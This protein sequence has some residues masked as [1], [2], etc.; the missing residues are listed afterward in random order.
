[1][2]SEGE[3]YIER[4]REAFRR[5]KMIFSLALAIIAGVGGYLVLH[6]GHPAE[7]TLKKAFR[8]VE[9]GDAAGVLALVDEE[10]PLGVL[11]D[12]DGGRLKRDF[13]GFI[14]KYRLEI[15]SPSFRV[16]S[17]KN[18]A[19]VEL[20]GGTVRVHSRSGSGIPL[21]ALGLGDSGLVFYMEKKEG[22]WLV[23]DV[24]YDLTQWI[25]GE[26]LPFSW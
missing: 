22:K 11:L 25:T 3:V 9:E 20:T 7:A 5:F 21:A 26:S 15:S 12:Q 1:M 19:E 17:E 16:R 8:M 10:G 2:T 6:R 14:E 4:V 13:E 24:N 23:E 18:R